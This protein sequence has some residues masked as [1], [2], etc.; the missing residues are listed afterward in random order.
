MPR[1]LDLVLPLNGVPL[2]RRRDHWHTGSLVSM[3]WLLLAAGTRS[4]LSLTGDKLLFMTKGLLKDKTHL[5]VGWGIRLGDISSILCD[6]PRIRYLKVCTL[7]ESW[8][9]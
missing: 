1:F 2:T 5:Q 7:G 3:L 9:W 4:S 8:A 6:S